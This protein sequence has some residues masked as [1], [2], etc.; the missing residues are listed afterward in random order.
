MVAGVRIDVAPAGAGR[1]KRVI[2]PAG[3][4]WSKDM[5][6]V[7]GTDRCQFAHVGFLLQGQVHV[8]YPD[9]C[10][11]EFIAPQAVTIEPGHDAWVVG[12]EPAILVEF[13]FKGDTASRFG[14][15]GEHVHGT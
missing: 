2:Y 1:I 9:G 15:N 11:E 3:F 14:L 12:D 6:P 10:T 5:K 4:R 7:S 8:E 13:D